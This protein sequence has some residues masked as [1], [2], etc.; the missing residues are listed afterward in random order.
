MVR[1]AR[2]HGIQVAARRELFMAVLAGLGQF[3]IIVRARLH[4]VSAPPSARFYVAPYDDLSV[5]MS[6]LFRLTDDGRFDT[7]QGFAVPDPAGGWT[8]SL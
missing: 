1:F 2:D 6:D 4:L 5:F 7:V 3:A 8:Y